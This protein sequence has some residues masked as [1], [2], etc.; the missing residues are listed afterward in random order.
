MIELYV[1]NLQFELVGEISAYKS[2]VIERN[3]D[4]VSQL[5]LRIASSP[6]VIELLK[7][8]NILTTQDNPNYGYIIEHFDYTDEAETEIEIHAYSLNYMLSWRSIEIQQR[9]HGNVED[10]IKYFVTMNAITPNNPNRIIPNLRLAANSG[11]NIEDESTKTGGE[12]IGHVFDICNKHEISMDIL[13]NHLDKKFDFVTWQ[14]VDRSTQ[15]TNNPHVIFSKEYD[16]I[17]NQKY[18]HNKVDYRTTAIVAGE[19]EGIE[20]TH[21]VTN[22]HLKGFNRR[23]L[24]VDARDLQSEYSDDNDKKKTMSPAEYEEALQKRGDE[25]LSDFQII[26]TF[27][28]EVDMY[29]QFTYNIDYKLGDRVSVRNDEIQR[30]LHPRVISA[31]L[32]SNKEGITLSINFGSNIPTIYEK[33]KKKVNK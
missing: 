16:N 20:R 3:Y 30:I 17:I 19:G 1:F 23:E 22:D 31:T 13:L 27:E 32:T 15:Q 9:Y 18:V 33:I 24:Y 10:L 8:D 14:G 2:L 29:S 21:V 26:E 4:K 6:G 5:I 7:H 11:I 12:V 25:K 28:S